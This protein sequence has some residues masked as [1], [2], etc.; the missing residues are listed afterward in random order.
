MKI[1]FKDKLNLKEKKEVIN[2]IKFSFKIPKIDTYKFEKKFNNLP[3]KVFFIAKNKDNKI[4]GLIVLIK[5]EMNYCGNVLQVLGMSFMAIEKKYQLKGLSNEFR[6]KIFLYSKK[7]D[8]ILGFAR[9]KM[10]GYWSRFGFLGF[11]N[12]GEINIELKDIKSENKY[13]FSISKI[14][15]DDIKKINNLSLID[16]EKIA[17]NIIRDDKLWSF[18]QKNGRRDL[19]L[20][21]ITKN[22]KIFSYFFCKDNK[23]FEIFS[24]KKNNHITILALKKFFKKRKFKEIIFQTSF[25]NTF[26]QYLMNYQY[27][28]YER[29][30][31]NGGHIVKIVSIIEFLNKNKNIFEKRLKDN[32]TN[33]F[34]AQYRGISIIYKNKKLNFEKIKNFK[35][36]SETL[37]E[38]TKMIFG[39]KLNLDQEFLLIFPRLYTQVPYIDHF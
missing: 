32:H 24:N 5:R 1:Y 35:N 36:N 9:K 16:N 20:Y 30:A 2:L 8:L 14:N 10:D 37:N 21:K 25:N 33:D 6:K 22:N 7:F 19:N 29:F 31:W 15:K 4:I 3:H 28:I 38:I 39:Q 27:T 34:I 26:I 18:Y 17:G 12:F 11:T 13:K 23:I